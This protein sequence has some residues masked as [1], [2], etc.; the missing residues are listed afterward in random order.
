MGIETAVLVLMVYAYRSVPEQTDD[1]PLVT[2]I[3]HS[4]HPYGCAASQDLLA[5]GRVSYR[6]YVCIEGVG[7]CVIND[8]MN[9]RHTNSLDVWVPTK[10]QEAAI[11]P[12][13]RQVIRMRGTNGKR[14]N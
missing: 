14:S 4:T 11:K 8:A 5:S 12:G 3:G 6:D 10:S 1:S 13:K 7:C 9:A 2:S